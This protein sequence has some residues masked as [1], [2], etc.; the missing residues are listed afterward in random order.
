MCSRASRG[1]Q[2]L[3]KLSHPSLDLYNKLKMQLFQRLREKDPA[4]RVQAVKAISE[5][6]TSEG[7]EDEEGRSVE[8]VLMEMMQYDPSGWVWLCVLAGPGL[9][10]RLSTAMFG[11]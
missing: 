7:L 8:D 11:G 4:V 9:T 6:Q 1:I 3:N 5:L 10:V 2:F